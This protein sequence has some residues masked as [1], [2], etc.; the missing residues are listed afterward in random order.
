M[1][2]T[3]ATN[4]GALMAQAAASS[5]NKDMELSMERLSTG[6]RING[7]SDDAAGVAIASRLTAEIKGTNQAIRNAL[8]GQA[9]IDTAEGAHVEV[10]NILQRMRELAVQASNGSNDENDRAILQLEVDALLTEVNRISQASTWA[11]Q[12]LLN[13]TAG[14]ALATS[15][16]DAAT[17]TFQVGSRTHSADQIVASVGAITSAALGLAGASESGSATDVSI[18]GPARMTV[19]DGT[20]QVEGDLKHGDVL[21]FDVNNVAVAITFSTTDQYTDDLDGVSAQFKDRVDALVT[22]GTILSPVE[23]V[24]NGN[25]SITL[26]QLGSPTITTVGETT[27]GTGTFAVSGSTLTAALVWAQNDVAT[28]TINGT[29]ITYTSAANDG[30]DSNTLVGVAA[31]FVDQI[32]SNAALENIVATDNGDG[33]ISIS[34]LEV[35]EIQSAEVTLKTAADASISYD[36][37]N[38]LTIGGSFVDG[39]NY[40]FDLFGQN[41]SVTASTTDG[42]ADTKAG[43]A[44]QVAAAINDLGLHGIT[45]AKTA[46]ENAVTIAGKV[47]A[48]NGVVNSGTEFLVTT[49]GAQATAE[50]HVNNDATQT[51]SAASYTAGDSYSFDVAGETFTL[52]VGSD[53]YENDIDG[54]TQ[55][56]IELIENAHIPGLAVVA[57]KG[58]TAGVAISY[59]LTKA[60]GGGGSEVITNVKVMDN[61]IA[62]GTTGAASSDDISISTVENAAAAIGKIDS[63]MNTINSQRAALGATSNRL[64][65]TV[66]NLTNISSNLQAGRGRIEDADFAAE[67]T[68]LAKSQIL[69]QASTAMLAQAN[70]S[71]Q[72]VLSLLQG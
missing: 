20:V 12:A 57:N 5:V 23:A 17:L 25:G 4:T 14:E 67:T 58:T 46:N 62:S 53:G 66:S 59:D 50:V 41:V 65:S 9:M 40:S 19:N 28:A 18:E 68:S 24:D 15:H 60:S 32:R 27:A 36:D 34:Q 61:S 47:T 37:T 56:M 35:P 3:V 69:Q 22:A 48:A 13:G 30:F 39:M 43:I 26:S 7:A 29:A 70:A 2:L 44:S 31:G 11:G 72:N 33:T 52:V 51:D 10:E 54:V 49:V 38:K 21:S 6:K 63:A 1:A 55:Q 42:F 16:D 71:K 45:A 8:D 64:D